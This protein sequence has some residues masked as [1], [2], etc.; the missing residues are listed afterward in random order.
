[1]AGTEGGSLATPGL[2]GVG[3]GWRGG[4]RASLLRVTSLRPD[5]LLSKRMRVVRVAS[6]WVGATCTTLPVSLL[7]RGTKI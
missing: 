5:T 1:M 3:V 2:A 7:Q 6:V 4:G